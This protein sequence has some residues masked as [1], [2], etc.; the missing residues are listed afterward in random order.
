MSVP[1]IALSERVVPIVSVERTGH[2]KILGTGFR[3]HRPDLL[4]TAKH[5]VAGTDRIYAADVEPNQSGVEEGFEERVLI[6]S[7]RTLV[8]DDGGADLAAVILEE[9]APRECFTLAPKNGPDSVGNVLGAPVASFGHPVGPE[10]DRISPRIMFGHVQRRFVHIT[11]EHKYLAYEL[12]FPAFPGQSGSPV[13]LDSPRLR[14][15]DNVLAVVTSSMVYS[16]RSSAASATWAIGL[17]LW[18]FADWIASI[19]STMRR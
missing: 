2:S 8:P 7:K 3:L 6:P 17:A 11:N 18:P 5:V 16:N 9:T 13:M 14:S 15:R 19:T 10:P 12:G 4:I 1:F